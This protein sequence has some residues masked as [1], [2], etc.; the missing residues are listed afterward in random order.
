MLRGTYSEELCYVSTSGGLVPRH[1]GPSAYFNSNMALQ[2][3]A[4]T[5]T[6][7]AAAAYVHMAYEFDVGNA[8]A[9]GNLILLTGTGSDADGESTVAGWYKPDTG[10]KPDTGRCAHFDVCA[11]LK[12]PRV[13]SCTAVYGV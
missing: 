2:L 11:T 7:A 5:S 8:S 3:R 13:L 10:S 1:D 4:V 12:S 9:W 6:S